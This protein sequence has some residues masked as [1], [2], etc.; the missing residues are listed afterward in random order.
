LYAIDQPL[1]TREEILAF[2]AERGGS[3]PVV[4]DDDGLVSVAFGV[5]QVPETFIID[6][7]GIVRVRWAGQ[8]DAITLGLLVQQQRQLYGAQ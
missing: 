3:W 4:L 8:I 1:D 2:F 6:P 7:D 5:A